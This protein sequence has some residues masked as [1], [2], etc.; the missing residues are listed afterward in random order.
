MTATSSYDA[1]VLEDSAARWLLVLHTALGVA[2][3]GASTHLV[4][5]LRRYLAGAYGRRRAVRRF[6]LLT[7]A[8]QLGG[9]AVGH[10]VYPTYRVEVRAALLENPAAIAREVE[11]RQ[12]ELDRVAAREHRAAPQLAPA[13]TQIRAAGRAA[14]WFDV[15]EHWLALGIFAALA[16]ALLLALWDPA[17]DG[18]GPRP[19]ALALAGFV[20][21]TL[22]LAAVIGILTASYRAL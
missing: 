8:L 12:A 15:K 10:V 7:L 20:A 14:R 2:A 9:F 11:A 3:V 19:V 4:I 17:R 22:W 18:D 21:A 5:Y 1:P 6:A 13:A 16:L